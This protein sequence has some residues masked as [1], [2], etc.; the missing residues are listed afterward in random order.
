MK[1]IKRDKSTFTSEL[2]DTLEKKYPK[3][4]KKSNVEYKRNLDYIAYNT[5]F[6]ETD[7]YRLM[8]TKG[9]D[10]V[11]FYQF[12]RERIGACAD[13]YKYEVT[14]EKLGFL[15]EDACHYLR[16][17]EERAYE[18]YNFL[19]EKKI[20]ITLE[21]HNCLW[22]LD[23]YSVWNFEII[24]SSRLNSRK[25]SAKSRKKKDDTQEESGES[26]V[27]E[28]IQGEPCTPGDWLEIYG[29]TGDTPF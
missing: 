7:E 13:G 3:C 24:N 26:T 29:D 2:I 22:V 28:I 20:L 11:L 19:V 16:M 23:E 17:N 15:I 8:I 1:I 10:V 12:I 27:E 14:D 9:Y 4:D 6:H 18:I 25:S 21:Y 5:N